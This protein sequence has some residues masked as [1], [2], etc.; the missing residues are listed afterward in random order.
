[1]ERRHPQEAQMEPKRPKWDGPAALGW[2]R[3]DGLGD[4]KL[5]LDGGLSKVKRKQ[6]RYTHTTA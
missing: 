1:M 2:P 4:S 5:R 3:W 6:T